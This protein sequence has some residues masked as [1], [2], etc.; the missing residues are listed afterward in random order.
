[1]LPGVRFGDHR[2]ISGHTGSSCSRAKWPVMA[3]RDEPWRHQAGLKTSARYDQVRDL[4]RGLGT[5]DR[6]PDR[7][8]AACTRS[9]GRSMAKGGRASTDGSIRCV[10]LDRFP[11]TEVASS[12][13]L[14]ANRR[15]GPKLSASTG[16]SLGIRATTYGASCEGGRARH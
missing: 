11:V 3:F 15:I 13:R 16:R 2:L 12:G 7:R 8:I 5:R 4:V 14:D 9:G 6:S 1:M 10:V